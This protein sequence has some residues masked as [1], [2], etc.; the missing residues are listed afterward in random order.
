MKWDGTTAYTTTEQKFNGRDQVLKTI[1]TDNVSNPIKTQEVTMTYDGHGRMKTRHYPIEDANTYTDWIYNADDSIQQI[2]DPRLAITNFTYGDPRGL[3]T[4]VS[5]SVPNGSTIPVT[6]TT[7]FT[8]DNL[9]NRTSMTDG[10]GTHAY[11]Y[12][13]LSRLTSE[14][15]TFTGLSGNFTTSYSYQISGKL[16]SVTDAFGADVYY[17]D[18]KAG[19]TTSITGTDFL[20]VTT[21]ASNIKFRAF[22]GVKEMTYGSSDNSV[23]SY[24]FDNRLRVSS[25]QSTSSVQSG[26]FVRKANYEYLADGNMKKADNIV[27]HRFDQ[28][29]RYD[30]AG[31]L[32]SNEFG[33]VTNSQNEQ[34]PAY[35]QTISY[36]AFSGMTARNTGIWGGSGGFAATYVNGRKQNSNEIYDAS[37]NIVDKTTTSTVYERWKFD[38]AGRNSEV[39]MRWFWAPAPQATSFDKTETIT[40]I[41]DG[42]GQVVKRLDQ[43]VSVQNGSTTTTTETTEYYLGSTVLGNVLTELDA[44]GTKKVTNVYTGSGVIAQQMNLPTDAE[45]PQPWSEVV[46]RHDDLVT[47]SYTSVARNGVGINISDRPSNGEIEP[48][49]G[50]VP[51]SDPNI[52][53]ELYVPRS[54]RTFRFAGDLNQPEYGC[55]W[56]GTPINC[57]L[58]PFILSGAKTDPKGPNSPFIEANIRAEGGLRRLNPI[59]RSLF[60]SADDSGDH[61]KSS[62]LTRRTGLHFTHRKR[63]KLSL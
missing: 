11:A 38:A 1:Q 51:N 39:K 2:I 27:D 62:L 20:D 53:D 26:G 21:Y 63:R 54:L 22:G 50:T 36:D 6:P 49:G 24:Q 59:E 17:N 31:R 37:G 40:Q 44:S 34:V 57:S 56:Q 55:G 5:Y 16:K 7:N 43:K 60:P 33:I 45:H 23:V 25:S 41:H 58:I 19:R 46:F 13:Q 42:D 14:T 29:N 15:K 52:T 35:A 3:T 30:F 9:G 12:D 32:T 47:G 18:D 28:T 61:L 4:Q 48:F 10:S 8:Y